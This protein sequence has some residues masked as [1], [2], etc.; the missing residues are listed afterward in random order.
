MN[1]LPKKSKMFLIIYLLWSAGNFSIAQT[2]EREITI[3]GARFTNE[4][5][6]HWIDEYQKNNPQITFKQDDKGSYEFSTDDIVIT[7]HR[8]EKN[9]IDESSQYVS[10]A[11]YGIL[12]VAN[13]NSSFAKIYGTKGLTENQIKQIFF[14]D[15]LEETDKKSLRIPYNVYTR[16]QRAPSPEVFAANFGYKQHQIN[17]RAIAGADI[18]LIQAIRK[19]TLGI[20]FVPVSLAYN[21]MT[22][23]LQDDLMVIPV[24]FDGNGKVSDNERFYTTINDVLEKLLAGNS[25]NIPVSD[26]Q[27]AFKKNADKEVVSFVSWILNNGVKSLQEYGYLAPDSK[28]LTIN[29]ELLNKAP[30]I[31]Q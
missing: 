10:I 4:L 15:P 13:K 16:V 11:R 25:K 1:L 8:L 9:E 19:D 14:F 30:F 27:L 5:F 21:T 2:S 12:I 22:G 6:R 31:Q 29:N 7:A 24:D 23:Q 26:I 17:G 20:T 3:S 18:H 28:N